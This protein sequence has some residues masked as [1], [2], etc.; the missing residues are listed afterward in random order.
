MG[1]VTGHLKSW[2]TGS[3]GSIVVGGNVRFI[4]DTNLFH[5]C[6]SLSADDFPWGEIGDFN[7]IELIVTDP[8]LSELDRQKKDQRPRIKRRAV[9]AIAWVRAMLQ[10]SADEHVFR[11]N[12]PRVLMRVSAQTPSL[13]HPNVLDLAVDDDRIV[14]VALALT[15]ENPGKDIRI[16]SDDTR[17]IAKSKALSIPFNFIPSS[18]KRPA[19]VDDQQKEISRLQAEITALQSTHPVISLHADGV[20]NR[21]ITLSRTA[22]RPPSHEEINLLRNALRGRVTLGRVVS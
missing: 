14:G 7:T 10:S 12:T 5:E 8:V 18:W 22:F 21:R 16:L 13:S 3:K 20:I 9:E 17:P 6:Q 2:S 19:E 1:K 11:Q 15:R 4:V